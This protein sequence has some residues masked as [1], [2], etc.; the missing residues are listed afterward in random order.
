MQERSHIPPS[1][2]PFPPWLIL[3]P[4]P[5]RPGVTFC[6]SLSHAH[7]VLALPWKYQ[8]HYY[9]CRQR[10]V[11]PTD[12]HIKCT[13]HRLM[14]PPPLSSC[15]RRHG[16][17]Q[18]ILQIFVLFSKTSNQCWR[19]CHHKVATLVD[20]HFFVSLACHAWA[21]FLMGEGARANRGGVH[22]GS[23]LLPLVFC[24]GVL[25]SL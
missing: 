13:L 3:F 20:L 7:V 24:D 14:L 18:A 2:P 22:D 11:F 21:I 25:I 16:I 6:P 19:R 4:L 1:P 10:S 15:L 23:A 17:V 8:G 5:V 12:H 9:G